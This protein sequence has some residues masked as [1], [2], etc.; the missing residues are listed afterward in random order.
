MPGWMPAAAGL[1]AAAE[2]K[3]P[4]L[5]TTPSFSRV[6]PIDRPDWPGSICTVTLPLRSH[7][8]VTSGQRAM[9][10]RT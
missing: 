8:V 3:A 10:S 1:A 5:L 4:A 9:E 7:V 6:V 2:A